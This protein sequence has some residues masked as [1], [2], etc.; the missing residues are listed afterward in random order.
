MFMN[1]Y[2]NITIIFGISNHDGVS[3]NTIKQHVCREKQF[4]LQNTITLVWHL[5]RRLSS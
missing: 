2:Y 4:P 1:V 3:H 5:S